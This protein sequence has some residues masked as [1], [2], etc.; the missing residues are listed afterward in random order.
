MVVEKSDAYKELQSHIKEQRLD[1][2]GKALKHE[3][4]VALDEINS[5]EN[6]CDGDGHLF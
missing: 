2:F 3:V 4:Q 1:K 5:V 6:S